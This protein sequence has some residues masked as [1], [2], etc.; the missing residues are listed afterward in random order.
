MSAN[1]INAYGEL[2][3]GMWNERNG[4]FDEDVIFTNGAANAKGGSLEDNPWD[5]G[6]YAHAVWT[7]GFLSV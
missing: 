1:K 4:D 6:T 3:K 2:V 7:D 5:K